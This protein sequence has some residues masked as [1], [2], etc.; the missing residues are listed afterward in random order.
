MPIYMDI[1][2][3]MDKVIKLVYKDIKIVIKNRLHMFKKVGES[4]NMIRRELAIN[5]TLRLNQQIT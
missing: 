4:M 3:Y 1:L 2:K 5:S